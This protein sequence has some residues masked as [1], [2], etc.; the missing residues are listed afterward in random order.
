VKRG[1]TVGVQ[2]FDRLYQPWY[3]VICR[4]P[5]K[6]QGEVDVLG[7]DPPHLLRLGGVGAAHLLLHRLQFLYDCIW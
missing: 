1:E 5:Q 6:L 2:R 4:F 3:L 7:N